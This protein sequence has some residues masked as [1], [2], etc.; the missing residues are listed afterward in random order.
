[1][2]FFAL[3]GRSCTAAAAPEILPFASPESPSVPDQK[4]SETA[5]VNFNLIVTWSVYKL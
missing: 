4:A 5:P 3:E 2:R 1:M